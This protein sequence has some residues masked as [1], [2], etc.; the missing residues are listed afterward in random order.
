MLS[1]LRLVEKGRLPI[2]AVGPLVHQ[3]DEQIKA[4]IVT[5]IRRHPDYGYRRIKEDLKDRA[6]I[7][8]NHKRLRKIL[9]TYESD[10]P[11][12]LPKRGK[13]P[14]LKLIKEV[15]QDANL[16]QNRTVDPLRVFCTDFTELRYCQGQKK[17][18]V[19]GVF[20]HPH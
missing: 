6:G 16:V 4:E 20:G 2:V 13:N 15:G 3:A 19:N 7:V 11:R 12:H 14:V 18:V 8:I 1:C 9:S 17:A 10:L 5:T